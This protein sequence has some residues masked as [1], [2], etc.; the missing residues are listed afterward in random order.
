MKV[1]GKQKDFTPVREDGSRV[2]ISYG[3]ADV[4]SK[5][6]T[7]QEIHLYKKQVSN[8]S[9]A[10][11]KNA[12]IADINARTDEKILS[13]FVWNEIPVWLSTENQSNFKAAYDINVQNKGALLP[14]KFKLGED[15]SGAAVYHTFETMA[16]FKDF[17][18]A[19]VAYVNQCLNDGWEEK[20]DI[21]WT[22]YETFFGANG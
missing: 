6:A 2:I 3:Y 21:D 1:F 20:D 15:A 9:L 4:D 22:P 12:V 8:V 18:L 17:Y 7:W 14:M 19:A 5:N 16:D 11:V 10:D 13:G